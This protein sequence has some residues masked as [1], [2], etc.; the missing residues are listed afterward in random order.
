MEENLTENKITMHAIIYT[1]GSCGPVNPGMNWGS[2]IHGY[3][4]K[5]DTVDGKSADRPTG[6]LI[7]DIGYLEETLSKQTT[8]KTVIPKYY[9]NGFGSFMEMGTNNTGEIMGAVIGIQELL[10]LENEDKVDT[11]LIKLDSTYVIGILDKLMNTDFDWRNEV[12]VNKEY[13]VILNDLIS[14]CKEN[15][16]TITTEKVTAHDTSIGN[17]TADRLAFLGRDLSNRNKIHRIEFKLTDSKKYWKP[18]SER[19]PFLNYKQLFFLNGNSSTENGIYSILN[20]KK[21]DEPGKKSHE[22]NFGLVIM[23]EK[24]PYIENIKS[25]YQH[26]LGTLE[27]ISSIDLN[28]LYSQYTSIYYELFG[29]DIFTY[30]NRGRR[31]IN[32]LEGDIVC[33]EIQPPG[34]AKRAVEKVFAMDRYIQEYRNRNN[35]C[36]NTCLIKFKD[37]TDMIY[38]TDDKGKLITLLTNKDKD[39]TIPYVSKTGKN[40]NIVLQLGKDIITRNQLNKLVKDEPVVTLATIMTHDNYIEYYTIIESKRTK[41]ISIWCNIF[42]NGLFLGK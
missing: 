35:E 2:G 31:Y 1:D 25:L 5:S 7:T 26:N 27:I 8:Y 3:I 17:N 14:K 12:K 30:G 28:V 39:I 41:D 24:V 18:D 13:W 32:V 38:K 4:Y 40:V 23:N 21:D 16:V 11:I 9:I 6:Y 36:G 33:A 22:A 37:I 20:Y 19:H 15:N 34:L 29:N 10:K 42:G